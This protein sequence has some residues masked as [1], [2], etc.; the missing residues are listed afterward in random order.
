MLLRTYIVIAVC[1]LVPFW[2]SA[3][4]DT[5]TYEF[6]EYGFS[7]P[8][9]AAAAKNTTTDYI[10]Y[11]F[12]QGSSDKLFASLRIYPN[13]GCDRPDS[14]YSYF[15]R[16]TKTFQD[17]TEAFQL[18]SAWGRTSALGWSMFDAMAKNDSGK[19]TS[20]SVKVIYNGKMLA[21]LDIV[22]QIMGS[23]YK[24]TNVDEI[25][26]NFFKNP[27]PEPY[28]IEPLNLKLLLNGNLRGEYQQEEKRY[29]L[30]RCDKLGTEYPYVTFEYALKSPQEMEFDLLE[31]IE[32][33][34]EVEDFDTKKIYAVEQFSHIK[35]SIYQVSIKLNSELG[36]GQKIYY[37]FNFNNRNYQI[38]IT[39]PFVQD[40]GMETLSISNQFDE[41]SAEIFAE[42]IEELISKI[43]KIN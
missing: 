43:Q 25:V 31:I 20:R 35:G 7:V 37:F 16:Y 6:P 19:Y 28:V 42:K 26:D 13:F 4:F 14:I 18:L 30:S 39:V 22:T 12:E 41:D 9:Y 38:C 33:N 27:I 10:E 32:F 17:N 21:V 5:K 2:A 24:G 1:L 36:A 23:S 3:Q 8:F 15:Y 40:D 11:N 29:Y 34:P